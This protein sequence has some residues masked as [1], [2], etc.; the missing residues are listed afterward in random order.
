MELPAV[1]GTEAEQ[2]AQRSGEQQTVGK[3]KA[4]VEIWERG[5]VVAGVGIVGRRA[6][7]GQPFSGVLPV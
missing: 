2:S 4:D 6:R 7:E 3:R 1:V 5:E